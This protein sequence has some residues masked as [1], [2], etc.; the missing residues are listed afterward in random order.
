MRD[1]TQDGN[2]CEGT[3]HES[4]QFVERAV[5][6]AYAADGQLARGDRALAHLVVDEDE[7][8]VRHVSRKRYAYGII[9]APDR[10]SYLATPDSAVL[11]SVHI[12]SPPFCRA[13]GDRRATPAVKGGIAARL[14][15]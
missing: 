12:C 2:L 15:P 10:A 4:L 7:E 3:F 8:R 5:G 13:R 9:S 1:V 11:A 6:R 14:D